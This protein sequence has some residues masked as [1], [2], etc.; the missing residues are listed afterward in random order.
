MENN[1]IYEYNT[2]DVILCI[3]LFTQSTFN[4]HIL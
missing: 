2:R 1:V 4:Y 3:Y